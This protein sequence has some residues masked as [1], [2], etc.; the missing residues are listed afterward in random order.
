MGKVTESDKDF[1]LQGWVVLPSGVTDM[2]NYLRN[3]I[4]VTVFRDEEYRDEFKQRWL[5]TNDKTLPAKLIIQ[6]Q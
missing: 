6:K 1:T 5:D 3:N 2:D 4:Y